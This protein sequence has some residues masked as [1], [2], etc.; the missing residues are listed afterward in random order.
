MGKRR[1]WAGQAAVAVPVFRVVCACAR[2]VD[3]LEGPHLLPQ[4]CHPD[5]DRT[6]WRDCGRRRP[7]RRA[8]AE[9]TTTP[10]AIT[11]R[12]QTVH[13]LITAQLQHMVRELG[14]E[15]LAEQYALHLPQTVRARAGELGR[16][17]ENTPGRSRGQCLQSMQ[18]HHTEMD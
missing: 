16:K 6:R 15:K 11:V 3:Y 7:D 10:T 18:K 2:R 9:R 12:Q 8:Q 13:Q 5:C 17:M 14:V 1:H 4:G